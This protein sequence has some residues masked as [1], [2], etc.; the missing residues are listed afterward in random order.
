MTC[1]RFDAWLDDGRPSD[2]AD[3][4]RAHAAS[5]ACCAAALAAALE[6]ESAFVA[7]ALT[8]ARAPAA[9]SD[10]VMQRIA[11]DRALAEAR[12]NEPM[13][14]WASAASEPLVA[15]SLVAAAAL[16]WAILGGRGGVSL[17]LVAASS[18]LRMPELPSFLAAPLA[19]P[20]VALGV[21][22]TLAPVALWASWWL[23]L[24]AAQQVARTTP[25]PAGGA[26]TLTLH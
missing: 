25:R 6:L 9:L 3:A 18:W 14:W 5:C 19:V 23:Y 2:G 13:A 10:R 26:A 8:T 21:G 1:T 16:A 15:L 12:A 11:L 4:A 17:V 20:A 7:S 24:W 22:L